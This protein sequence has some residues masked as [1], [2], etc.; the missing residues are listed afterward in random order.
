MSSLFYIWDAKQHHPEVTIDSLA[1]AEYYATNSQ[2]T[3]FTEKFKNWLLHVESIMTNPEL[4]ANFDEEI[5]GSFTNV[6]RYFDAA[7]NVFKIEQGLLVKSKYLYKILIETLRQHDL[8]A[9]DARSY[10]F[11]SQ[12]QI[13]PDQHNIERMLDAVSAVT[14]EQL[15]QFQS[16]PATREQL[17][18]FSDRWLK[19]NQDILHFLET[20]KVNQFNELKQGWFRDINSK[21][22]ESISILCSTSGD[23]VMYTD[24][25][26]MSYIE[27]K[28]NTILQISRTHYITEYTLQYLSDIHGINGK[29]SQFNDPEQLKHVL[30]QIYNFLIYDAEKHRDIET[31]SQWINHGSEK[32]YTSP[33]PRLMLAKYLNDPLYDDLVAEAVPILE[34]QQR[35]KPG[36]PWYINPS[37]ESTYSEVQKRLDGLLKK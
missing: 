5:I 7:D 37:L 24:I 9:F 10:L 13:F 30:Q 12:K 22:Y 31:L 8:V 1:Q 19:K 26:L 34:S 2:C 14:Q 23:N 25:S 33:Y 15:E 16:I 20:Q 32:A 36:H 4:S 29:A 35:V 21:I 27:L 11:F 6:T 17:I 3:G 18:L 28:S